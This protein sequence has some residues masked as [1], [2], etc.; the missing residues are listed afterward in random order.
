MYERKIAFY[1]TEDYTMLECYKFNDLIQI[2]QNYVKSKYDDTVIDKYTLLITDSIKSA[3]QTSKIDLDTCEVEVLDDDT[4]LYSL[5]DSQITSFF[6][7]ICDT[8]I[9]K[10]NL[11]KDYIEDDKN[12]KIHPIS[13]GYHKL[14]KKFI[15]DLLQSVKDRV[16]KILDENLSENVI[17]IYKSRSKTAITN[18]QQFDSA[19]TKAIVDE[20]NRIMTPHGVYNKYDNEPVD[21]LQDNEDD[22]DPYSYLQRSFDIFYDEEAAYDAYDK[23][24]PKYLFIAFAYARSVFPYYHPSDDV[25]LKSYESGNIIKENAGKSIDELMEEIKNIMKVYI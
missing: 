10:F 5:N 8:V 22:S 23:L 1:P 2:V 13:K 25:I 3:F 11:L 19:I 24:E 18:I 15:D 6:N 16:D 14:Y 9:K 12:I 21:Y 4:I 17:N 7:S 20:I